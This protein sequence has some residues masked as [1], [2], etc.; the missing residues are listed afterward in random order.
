[1]QA[2][3]PYLQKNLQSVIDAVIIKIWFPHKHQ[4]GAFD[5]LQRTKF[6]L[7]RIP[8]CSKNYFKKGDKKL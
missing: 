6:N 7:H 1:M 4:N 3:I 8:D 2:A 5:V